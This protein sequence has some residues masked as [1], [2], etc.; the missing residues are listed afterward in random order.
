V[1][2]NFGVKP[3]KAFMGALKVKDTVD[4]EIEATVPGA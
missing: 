1:Q 2:S 4:I 3:F